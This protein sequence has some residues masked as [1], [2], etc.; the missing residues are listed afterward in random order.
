MCLTLC[1]RMLLLA[2]A[3]SG[4]VVL[5]GCNRDVPPVPP[6]SP[7]PAPV[8]TPETVARPA[9]PAATRTVAMSSATPGLA[10]KAKAVL[11]KGSDVDIAVSG[12]QSPQQFLAV[13]HAAK[14]VG[15]PFMVLK[16]KVLTERMSLAHAITAL[17]KN[18]VNASFEV[19]RAESEAKADLAKKTGP[20]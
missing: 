11:N 9:R 5:A 20:Q 12:F 10:E 17:S 7:A 3:F 4:V 14:N 13:A 15:I 16:E 2:G 19:K 6:P 1:S 18:S 8:T